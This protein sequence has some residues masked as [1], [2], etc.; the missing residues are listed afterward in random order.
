MNFHGLFGKVATMDDQSLAALEAAARTTRERDEALQF[1]AV[2]T[3]STTVV[4][5]S[6]R[7][8]VHRNK[9]QKTESKKQALTFA[10]VAVPKIALP[11]ARMAGGGLK[12]ANAGD[13]SSVMR[14]LYDDAHTLVQVL[15]V[16]EKF[17][18][19]M[20][21]V[22]NDDGLS[23]QVNHSTGTVSLELILPRESFVRFEN[24]VESAVCTV[25]SSSAVRAIPASAQSKHSLSFL[26]HQCGRADEPLHIQLN[27]RDGNSATAPIYHCHL[28]HCEDEENVVAIPEHSYQYQITMDAKT[29]L[30]NVRLLTKS[31]STI[32]LTLRA[33]ANKQLCFEM[34]S[35]SGT[36]FS[37]MSLKFAHAENPSPAQ[38]TIAR[39]AVGKPGSDLKFFTNHRLIAAVIELVASFGSVSSAQ[40]IILR[41]GVVLDEKQGYREEPV[42]IEF[43]MRA[44]TEGA[45]SVHAWVATKIIEI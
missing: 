23:L 11:N 26:Y 3:S 38:C 18:P 25:V 4:E 2:A 21:L 32:V 13:P 9:K 41:L 17:M 20:H 27:P 5:A 6:D 34:G 36:D 1:M 19:Y 16:F 7:D 12:S 8:A 24:L 44:D 30:A 15:G 40:N 22:F 31:A 28:P 33:D 45:F 42:R 39:L 43:P 37:S 29:F 14:V 10:E 35:V